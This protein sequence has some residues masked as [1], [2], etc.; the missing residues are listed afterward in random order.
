MKLSQRIDAAITR[1]TNGRAAMRIPADETD[2]DI[3]LVDA[4]SEIERLRK[5]LD[6]LE[7]QAIKDVVQ[8]WMSIPSVEWDSIMTPNAQIEWR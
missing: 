3:V 7:M 5:T 8:G 4:K 6:S 2:P 1:I